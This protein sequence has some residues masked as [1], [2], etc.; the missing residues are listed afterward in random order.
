MGE[1]GEPSYW[2]ASEAEADM[3]LHANAQKGA[4]ILLHDSIE[5]LESSA[6]ERHQ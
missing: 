6:D 5:A 1:P 3:N 2:A 4:E